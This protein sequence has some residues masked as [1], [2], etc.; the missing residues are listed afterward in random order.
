M[1]GSL[2]LAEANV[3]QCSYS[4]KST[5]NVVNAY[6][7]VGN[8][9]MTS[10]SPFIT[11]VSG[12]HALGRTDADVQVVVI[13]GQNI[14]FFPRGL[15]SFSKLQAISLNSVGIS[16][17]T[18]DDLAQFPN[19]VQ[20]QLNGNLIDTLRR[21]TFTS[22][23][24]LQFISIND[25][26]LRH[27]APSAFDNLSKLSI[28]E[29]RNTCVNEVRKNR[30]DVQDLLPIISRNC[31]PTCDMITEELLDG[32]NLGEAI[33]SKIDNRLVPFGS[34]LTGIERQINHLFQRMDILESVLSDVI[35]VLNKVVNSINQQNQ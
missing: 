4:V 28:L 23:P 29:L 16:E 5:W 13:E 22:N 6:T 3:L 31:A 10:D 1:L 2:A 9:I 27:I 15:V 17:V 12:V 11:S 20:L 32:C 19:L 8:I 21:L 26:P 7:C 14:R 35:R 33:N 30:V 25:N 34:Q 24:N 18:H